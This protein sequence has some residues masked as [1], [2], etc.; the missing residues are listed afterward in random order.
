M[1]CSYYPSLL[2]LISFVVSIALDLK[3]LDDSIAYSITY[4]SAAD[5]LEVLHENAN[6]IMSIVSADNEKY[7]CVLPIIESQVK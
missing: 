4:K 6:N 3:S 5:E 1:Y 2:I 7:E